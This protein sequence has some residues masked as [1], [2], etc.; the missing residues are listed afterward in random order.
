MWSEVD[1]FPIRDR[2]LDAAHEFELKERRDCCAQ[3]CRNR[4][5][6]RKPYCIEHL[7]RLD[8]VR[9]LQEELE[10]QAVV[11]RLPARPAVK[12]RLARPA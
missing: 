6:D 3:G 10:R 12:R 5:S 2:R 1:G 9:Q 7:D 11:R 8:Y 4:T